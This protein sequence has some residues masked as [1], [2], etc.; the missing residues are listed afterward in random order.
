MGVLK[1]EC[2]CRTRDFLRNIFLEI[3]KKYFDRQK[4]NMAPWNHDKPITA[5]SNQKVYSIAKKTT[6]VEAILTCNWVL[7][8]EF[9]GI[10]EKKQGF[11]MF[12]IA[13]R[14]ICVLLDILALILLFGLGNFNIYFYESLGY[15][16]GYSQGYGYGNRYSLDTILNIFWIIRI[17][18]GVLIGLDLAYNIF[19]KIRY[20]FKVKNLIKEEQQGYNVS[21]TQAY[22]QVYPQ[23]NPQAYPQF[24]AQNYPQTY[25]QAYPQNYPQSYP[26]AY[27][28]NYPQATPQT[29]KV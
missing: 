27:P 8:F 7:G 15:G 4:H 13:Y 28:Q 21:M 17:V 12:G 11:V 16:S 20:Q 3:R 29:Q 14:I 22:P 5:N 9:Y 2:C 19:F 25:P 18:L 6:L 1:L 23:A 10:S 26:P 24:H